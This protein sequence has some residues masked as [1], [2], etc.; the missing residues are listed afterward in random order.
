LIIFLLGAA[1]GEWTVLEIPSP[2]AHPHLPLRQRILVKIK[3]L[4]FK[5]F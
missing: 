5:N 3:E 2:A 1:V 4:K